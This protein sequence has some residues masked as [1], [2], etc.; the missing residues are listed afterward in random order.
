MYVQSSL[1]IKTYTGSWRKCPSWT[2][3]GYIE[4]HVTWP[5]DD[6]C[7]SI[8]FV[9]FVC[10]LLLIVQLQIFHSTSWTISKQMYV[11]GEGMWHARQRLFNSKHIKLK[12][13]SGEPYWKLGIISIDS[14]QLNQTLIIII[15]IFIWSNLIINLLFHLFKWKNIYYKKY[16][17]VILFVPHFSANLVKMIKR[18][19]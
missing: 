2:D 16:P 5:M 3:A 14:I 13:E 7:G 19:H 12:I 17:I 6:F 15:I 11:N 10:L 8:D 4:Y 9:L 1:Y 18:H